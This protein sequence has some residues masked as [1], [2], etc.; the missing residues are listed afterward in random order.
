M[1]ESRHSWSYENPVRIICSTKGIEELDSI[2]LS[3][4]ILLVTSPSFTAKGCVNHVQKAL[5]KCQITVFDQVT[6]NPELETIESIYRELRDQSFQTI[7]ALGGG[8]AID[9]AKALKALF[10]DNQSD[11]LIELINN[12]FKSGSQIQ[13]IAVPTTS[14]TGSEV[15]PFAT[16]WDSVSN[17]KYSLDGIYPSVALLCPE[18]TLTLPYK[19]TLFT[20]L[21]TISHA[22]ES[23]WNVNQTPF[24]LLYATKAL[25]LACTH[26]PITLATPDN[27]ESRQQMQ[28]AST[29]AGIAI[30]QTKTAI[31]HAISYPLTLKLGVPHGLAAGFCL[32]SI[33]GLYQQS[34][35]LPNDISMLLIEVKSLLDSFN[36]KHQIENFGSQKTIMELIP[37]M[38]DPSRVKNFIITATE[39]QIE[40]IIKKSTD[41]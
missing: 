27:L 34:S 2:V 23:I 7:I 18:L 31:A 22:L 26:L 28:L 39:K 38:F 30:S 17:K 1:S 6:P 35:N 13:L 24:S 15:T 32:E 36:L 4:N 14:G 33:I 25:E 40:E 5:N 19:Q 8:S 10:S 9:T 11:S 20:G 3:G 29:Y 41:A 21:D 16:I 12:G 37:E